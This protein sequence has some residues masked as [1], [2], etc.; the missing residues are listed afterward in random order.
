[1]HSSL[2]TD[3]AINKA[4]GGYSRYSKRGEVCT[5][6]LKVKYLS[7]L[8]QYLGKQVMIF[9]ILKATNMTDKS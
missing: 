9:K 3:I 4:L 2:F 8:R 1:M 5:N 6:F 7:E